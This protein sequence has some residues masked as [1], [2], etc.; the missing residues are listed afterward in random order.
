MIDLFKILFGNF[1]C[2]TNNIFISL[3]FYFKYYLFFNNKS[4]IYESILI[5]KENFVSKRE[6][7]KLQFTLLVWNVK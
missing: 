7:C 3:L 4:K 6:N 5:P 1:I 2:F